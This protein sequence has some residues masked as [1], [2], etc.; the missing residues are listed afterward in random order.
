MKK[1]VGI[2]KDMWGLLCLKFQRSFHV[3][4]NYFSVSKSIFSITV[5]IF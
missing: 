5:L 1:A 4:T 3:L 2:W